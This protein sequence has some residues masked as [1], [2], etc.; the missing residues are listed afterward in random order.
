MHAISRS[1]VVVRP[2]QPFL[3]WLH[4]V[5]P[6]SAHLTLKDLRLEPTIYLLRDWET[7]EQA[8][9][10]FAH[11]SNGIFEEELNGWYRDPSVWPEKRDLNRFLQWFECGFHSM[12]ID[13]CDNK[14]LRHT[15]M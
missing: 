3:D 12:V 8:L 6:T 15:D 5:D 7:D 10:H 13:V 2:A 4:R 11:V 14:C 1:A 9:K